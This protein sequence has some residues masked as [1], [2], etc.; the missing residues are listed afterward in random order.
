[1]DWRRFRNEKEEEYDGFT[2]NVLVIHLT[3]S[4]LFFTDSNVSPILAGNK[5]LSTYRH[6]V[7]KTVADDVKHTFFVG[8]Q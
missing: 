6:K 4:L 7:Q 5:T 3:L 8:A 2:V 1:M